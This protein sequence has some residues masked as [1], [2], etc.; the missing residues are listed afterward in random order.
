MFMG[1]G[2]KAAGID[3]NMSPMPFSAPKSIFNVPITGS[4]RFAVKSLSLAEIKTLGKQ[5][6]A[7]VNDIVLA[8]CSGALRKYMMDK[9]ALPKK[10]LIASVPVS[11]RQVN[12]TGNHITYVISNLATN[13]PDTMTR[14]GMIGSSTKDAKNELVIV[15]ADAATNFPVMAKGIVAV[16]TRLNFSCITSPPSNFTIS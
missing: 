8:L 1:Q 15:S 11:V 4:R 7:T 6:N 12:R 13:E 9:G 14:L 2:L 3:K 16:L 5:A 10:S